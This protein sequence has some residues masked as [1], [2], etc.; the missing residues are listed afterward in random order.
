MLK[1]LK[2]DSTYSM[3]A[4]VTMKKKIVN[5]NVKFLPFRQRQQRTSS[6]AYVAQCVYD[7]QA[8]NHTVN[9]MIK[10]TETVNGG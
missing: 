6:S 9:G 4:I 10:H 8:H 3:S 2:F 1:H 5:R 7:L